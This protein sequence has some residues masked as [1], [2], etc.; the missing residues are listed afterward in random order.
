MGVNSSGIHAP[1]PISHSRSFGFTPYSFAL[2]LHSDRVAHINKQE[3]E[4]TAKK[5]VEI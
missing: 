1:K 3:C 2:F 5:A 4:N